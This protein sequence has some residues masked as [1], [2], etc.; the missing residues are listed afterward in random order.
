LATWMATD[1]FS[2]VLMNVLLN[3]S[4]YFTLLFKPIL[5]QDRV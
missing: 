3:I 1:Y 4:P 5:G 2:A